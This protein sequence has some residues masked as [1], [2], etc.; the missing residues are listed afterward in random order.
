MKRIIKKWSIV[1]ISLFLLYSP[2]LVFGISWPTSG[3]YPK[4]IESDY[5]PRTV[6]HYFHYGLDFLGGPKVKAVEGGKIKDIVK[7]GNSRRIEIEGKESGKKV[8]Y[9]HVNALP[10]I[11]KGDIVTEGQEIATYIVPDDSYPDHLDIRF[12]YGTFQSNPLRDLFSP[13]YTGSAPSIPENKFKLD[14]EEKEG[15]NLKKKGGD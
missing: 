13:L 8:W 4:E 9:M 7:T 14:V 10:G 11:K 3:T 5:G 6:Y 1:L 12:P 15:Y 2:N